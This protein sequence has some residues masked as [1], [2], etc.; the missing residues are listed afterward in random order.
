[1]QNVNHTTRTV[2]N[3]YG[4][5]D[6][7]I[8][9]ICGYTLTRTSDRDATDE[10]ADWNVQ[11]PDGAPILDNRNFIGDAPVEYGINWSAKGTQTVADAR[12]YALQILQA[13]KA[14]EAFSEIRNTYSA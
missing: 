9:E 11:R 8:W 1:M 12:D 7:E 2:Q 13:C 4:T 5:F 14:A 10:P 6:Q 3:D